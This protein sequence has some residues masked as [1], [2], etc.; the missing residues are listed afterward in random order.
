MD[1][2]NLP[3]DVK[4]YIFSICGLKVI[5]IIGRISKP[6][7]DLAIKIIKRTLNSVTKFNTEDLTIKELLFLCKIETTKSNI[8]AGYDS[9]FIIT[10]EE[11]CYTTLSQAYGFGNNIWGQLAIDHLQCQYSPIV[12][13]GLYHIKSISVSDIHSLLLSQDNEAYICGNYIYENQGLSYIKHYSIPPKILTVTDIKQVACDEKCSVILT[14]DGKVYLWGENM[15]PHIIKPYLNQGYKNPTVIPNLHNIICI[16]MNNTIITALDNKG[17]IYGFTYKKSTS[18][19]FNNKGIIKL[20]CEIDINRIFMS[21][22]LNACITTDF[23]LFTFASPHF[24]F[25]DYGI[26]G[27][28]QVSSGAEHMLILTI[29]GEVYGYGSNSCGQLG[30][31]YKTKIKTFEMIPDFTNVIKIATGS[32]H[33]LI[34]T[35]DEKVYSFGQ[36]NKGQLGLGSKKVIRGECKP[37]L[38]MDLRNP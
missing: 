21:K 3:V 29:E 5:L 33:S 7:R 38:V 10:D 6:L 9:S 22:Y 27:V 1:F 30:L 26:K 25:K 23:E 12:I 18:D 37:K 15:N 28:V 34:M 32:Y 20:P 14:N 19:I 4:E 16:S 17:D 8:I 24:E 11:T 13:K 2:N 35:A 36:N 31:G